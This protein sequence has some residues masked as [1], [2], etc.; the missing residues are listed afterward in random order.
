MKFCVQCNNKLYHQLN[1]SD[2]N[3]LSYYCR[4]CGYCD[5][6]LTEEGVCVMNTVLKQNEQKFNHIVNEYTILDPTLPRLYNLRCPNGQCGSQ[7][8][9]TNNP[10]VLYIRY[11]NNNLKYLYLCTVCNTR[12]T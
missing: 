5:N 1:D 10:E 8:D 4:Y 2:S 11:D 3:K 12:W 9:T 7:A 6:T